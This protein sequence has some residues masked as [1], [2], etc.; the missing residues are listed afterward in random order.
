[1]TPDCRWTFRV[2]GALTRNQ[3]VPVLEPYEVIVESG[4]RD[5]E[6]PYALRGVGAVARPDPAGLFKT[7]FV[8]QGANTPL[9]P[10]SSLSVFVRESQGKWQPYVV[11]VS[12]A[13]VRRSSESELLIDLGPVNIGPTQ[14]LYAGGAA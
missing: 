12:R 1:M 14:L 11:A 10:P 4:V 5:A 13:Q 3:G 9:E 8:T 7:S 2:T 6:S